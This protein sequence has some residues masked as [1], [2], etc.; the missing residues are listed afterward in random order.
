MKIPATIVGL[1]LLLATI[2]SAQPSAPPR[3]TLPPG[4]LKPPI[5]QKAKLPNP[6]EKLQ[7]PRIGYTVQPL[8][9]MAQAQKDEQ[10]NFLRTRQE[11]LI[12][13]RAYPGK[14]IDPRA[15][16]D[17]YRQLQTMRKSLGIRHVSARWR[18][19][20]AQGGV[21]GPGSGDSGDHGGPGNT[22]GTTDPNG[23]AWTSAG[24]TNINGRVTSIAI[25]PTNHNRLFATTVGGIWR[26]TNAGRRWQRV[27]DD[28]LATVFASLAI[29]PSTPTE[30]LAG[31]GDPNYGGAGPSSGLGIWRS[32]T[33]GDPASWSKVSPPAMDSQVI[34]RIRFDPTA[35]NDVYV[36][37]SNGVWL[38][39]HGGG[40]ITFARIGAF[41][42]W[43]SDMVVDFSVT[44]RRVYAG[45]R[46]ASAGFG[47][48]I[49]K[50]DG[51]SWTKRDTG[52]PTVNGHTIALA[53]AAS[54]TQVIYAKVEATDGQLLGVFKTTTAAETPMGGGN[55]WANLPGAS[56]LN[57][58][59]S[60]GFFYSWYNSVLEVDPTDQN[61]VYGGGLNIW[62]TTNGGTSWNNVDGGADPAYP[63]G[64]HADQ[65]AVAFD[66][67]SPHVIYIGN[68]GGIDKTTDTSLATWHWFDSSH[69]MVL[70][71]FYRITSQQATANLIAG[72]SQDNGTEISFGNRTWYNPGGCDGADVA[73]DGQNPDTLYANCNGGLYELSNP[74]PATSG[75]GSTITWSSPSAPPRP[76]A[77][78]D[79]SAQGRALVAGG[80]TCNPHHVLKTTDGVNWTSAQTLPAGGKV[81]FLSIAPSSG[82]QTYYA[83]V[84]YS[85]PSN[86]DCPGF[87]GSPFAA[88]IYRTTNGGGV[89]NTTPTGLP[90]LWPTSAAV[91]AA[92]PDRAVATFSGSGNVFMTLDGTS[93]SSIQ[94]SGIS[95]LPNVS[96]NAAVFDPFNANVVYVATDIG[97]FRGVI[98]VMGGT[99]TAAWTP[100]DEGL[101]DGLVTTGIQANRTTGILTV[102]SLGHGV[103][104]RDVRSGI[105]CPAHTLIV[106]DN[107][108]DRGVAPSPSNTPDPEHPIVDSARPGFYKPDDTPAGRV[109]WWAS[110]DIRID[111]PAV[112]AV[113]NQ[114]TAVDHVEFES[115]PSLIGDCPAG[116]ML[117]SNPRRGQPARAYV[118]I[119]NRGLQPISQVRVIAMWT[120]A[121]TTVPDLPN[122][123]WTTTFP[124]G[125]TTCGALSG[126][127]GW[128]AVD[129]VTPCRLVPNVNPDLPEV[130][131]FDWAVP[132]TAAE[133]TCM[134]VITESADDPIDPGVRAAN[135]RRSWVLVPNNRQIAQRNLHVVDL[136]APSGGGGGEPHTMSMDV[137][138][139]TRQQGIEL[140]VSQ[141]GLDGRV[142]LFMPA[143]LPADLKIEGLER[144][145]IDTPSAE[146]LRFA[147][148]NKLDPSNGYTL[149]RSAAVLALPIPPGDSWRIG[150]MAS[151]KLRPGTAGRLVFMARQGATVL[152]GNSYVLRVPLPAGETGIAGLV[153][154]R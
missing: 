143:G 36:A 51:V 123:F 48:G 60:P 136:S 2:A 50:W 4:I 12:A 72:G 142:T 134:M 149:I 81:T 5:L 9:A 102:G 139:R 8:G 32:T 121:T 43:A 30:V 56:S 67:S 107:V 109:Y 69:G 20:R 133:H 64:I 66:P 7:P 21:A 153:P 52:I 92:N 63:Y 103:F 10:E 54:N 39:T 144:T 46:E 91:D 34:Y 106:R 146:L 116:L 86:T 112:D 147:R 85:P 145:R 77:A 41:D 101:P 126:A 57:D 122:D 108:F 117:D 138:N 19:P 25:D 111:V 24:P 22:P 119:T 90:N 118:Q 113:K 150:V 137:P 79:D 6:A 65:H 93:W 11:L 78:T 151:A 154:P 59:G 38:G 120:D 76:P 104:Q 14:E 55:A 148:Q 127:T 49:W 33:S 135:E 68:D 35:P 53:M 82:F 13:P 96:V 71:E 130:A 61:V 141:A 18:D 152:G 42:A 70:T 62:R 1:A 47:R 105:T 125:T 3:R 75:G 114:L 131:R 97:V 74:V 31:G 128:H 17:A 40:G 124:A 23:C 29:N 98:T 28:F 95:A 100:F 84:V 129:P 140:H 89:W 94:G 73:S 99:P 45:V 58:S 88:T 132:A 44:P 15:R 26:S 27:S 80:D 37:T 110:D 16:V 83:G 115:C 87:T